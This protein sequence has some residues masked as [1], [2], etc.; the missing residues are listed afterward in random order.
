MPETFGGLREKVKRGT[1]SAA[2]AL[3]AVLDSPQPSKPLIKWLRGRIARGVN[4]TPPPPPAEVP[5]EAPSKSVERRL[6]T[7][8]RRDDGSTP[9]RA[10]PTRNRPQG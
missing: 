6:K 9:I 10:E 8:K 4:P 1:L 7:Q 2:D 3:S 5:P